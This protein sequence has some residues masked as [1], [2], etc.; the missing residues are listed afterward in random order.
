MKR[1]GGGV[2]VNVGSG[3]GWGKPGLL[4]YSA[5]KG[6]VFA[7]SAALAYDHFLDHIR[8]N[9]VAPG[10]TLTGQ[11]EDIRNYTTLLPRWVNVAGRTTTSEDVANAVAQSPGPFENLAVKNARSKPCRT[12]ST[13]PSS[14]MSTF[15]F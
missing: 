5:S 1:Q 9:V 4:A 10:P 14:G 8:V 12:S 15:R 7:F 3:S 11:M 2:I 6:G 13:C